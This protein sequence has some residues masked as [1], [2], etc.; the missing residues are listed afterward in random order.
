M[1]RPYETVLLPLLKICFCSPEALI[2]RI[3]RFN[4]FDDSISA[5]SCW[6]KR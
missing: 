2:E 3:R 5:F 4:E 1:P 6:L